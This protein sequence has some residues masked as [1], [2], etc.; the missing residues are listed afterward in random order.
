MAEEFAILF[1]YSLAVNLIFCVSPCTDFSVVP[2]LLSLIRDRTGGNLFEI[3][4]T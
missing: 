3:S 1:I 2:L 4:L